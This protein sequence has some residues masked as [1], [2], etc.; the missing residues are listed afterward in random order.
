MPAAW[1]I[2]EKYV[3]M[4]KGLDAAAGCISTGPYPGHG[5]FLPYMAC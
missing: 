1:P 4:Q 3:Q 5:V 2:L